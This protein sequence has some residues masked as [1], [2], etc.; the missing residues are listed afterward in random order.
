MSQTEGEAP[1]SDETSVVVEAAV[2]ESSTV[3]DVLP[4]RNDEIPEGMTKSQWKKLRR[5]QRFDERKEEFKEFKRAKRQQQR[6]NRKITMQKAIADG[7]DL[8]ELY[9]SKAKPKPKPEDQVSSG[10]KVIMDCDFDDLMLEK[11]VVSLSNQLTRC[12]SDNR[13]NKY[14]VDLQICSFNKRLKQRFETTL[15]DY[16]NWDDNIQFLED[17]LEAVLKSEDPESDLSNVVYL[18]ADTDDVLE[19]LKEGEIYV[20]GG[21]VDKGRHKFLC[22]NKAEKLGIKTKRLPID[23]F[24]KLSGRRVLATSHVFELLLK[25]FEYRDWKR[26]FEEV[27]PQ[28]KLVEETGVS[29]EEKTEDVIQG[30]N[31]AVA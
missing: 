27:I 7:K 8:A 1:I 17:D 30:H 31:E 24:I 16:T 14:H 10:C 3:P 28:R 12:Y 26:S 23:E 2:G 22:K 5:R 20:V 15:S 21:I 19:E 9:P 4:K 25:W 29:S 11:E 6:V 13:R 18:S